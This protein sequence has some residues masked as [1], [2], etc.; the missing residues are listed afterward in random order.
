MS[1]HPF[2]KL[3]S[4]QSLEDLLAQPNTRNSQN[5]LL[6]YLDVFVLMVMLVITLITISNINTERQ[7]ADTNKTKAV[8]AKKTSTAPSLPEATSAV[9]PTPPP[10]TFKD[11]HA[12]ETPPSEN[13]VA[14]NPGMP[15]INANSTESN[16]AAPIPTSSPENKVAPE[17]TADSTIKA[18][19]TSQAV[20]KSTEE[21][22]LQQH[23]TKTVTE[24][25]LD[26]S[27][28]IKV[29][30]GYAQLEIQDNVLFNSSEAGLTASGGALLKR[31]MPL[32]KQSVGLILIEGH[33]DNMPIKTAQFPSNWELG[34]SR[35]TSVLH[36]LVLQQLDSNRLRAITYADTMPI[37]DNS[38]PEG[39]EKNRRVN[40]LIKFSQQ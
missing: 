14:P 11:E 16:S 6:T 20:T 10:P 15:N 29:A 4:S 21:N 23:L 2:L 39:R 26:K 5:W 30:Q 34:A 27:V 40:I 35:A 7:Q 17:T 37:A 32:L 19:D 24:F 3:Q 9:T 36:F 8:N 25:G 13:K 38:T 28:T 33:T 1:K 12:Q 18:I 31:L 22:E